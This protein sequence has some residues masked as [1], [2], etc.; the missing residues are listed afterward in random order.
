MSSEPH[1]K[2]P[3]SAPLAPDDVRGA[4]RALREDVPR[5]EQEFGSE[6]HRRLVAAG[7]PP[8][9]PSWLGWLRDAFAPIRPL[10]TGAVLGALVTATAFMLLGPGRPARDA[11]T[12][13]GREEPPAVPSVQRPLPRPAGGRPGRTFGDHHPV[14]DRLGDDIGAQRAER[15]RGHRERR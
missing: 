5:G 1:D 7:T 8:S 9:H 15:S 11:D 14:R 4:L 6:L 10:L 12:S 3:P 13:V 2:P